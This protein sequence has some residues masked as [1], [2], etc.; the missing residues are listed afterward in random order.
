MTKLPSPRGPLSEQL[1]ERLAQ[2][3][4]DLGR[5]VAAALG[6]PLGDD[7]QLALF[8]LQEL[9]YRPIDGVD[10]AWE[11][12]P[13][14]V[15][16]RIRFEH[17]LE[18]L[19]RAAAG[20]PT[21]VD[22]GDVPDALRELV[23]A[24][25]GP[26]LSGWAQ[27]HAS[28]DHLR[29]FAVHRAAYQLKEADPHSTA[30]PRLP[31]GPAKTALLE[32]QLDEYGPQP[33]E[34]HAELFAET[35]RGLGLDPDD[36]PDLDRLPA[37]TLATNTSLGMLASSRRLVGALLGHLAVF[38]MTSVEPMSR[39]AAAV[40]RVLPGPDGTRAAR[41]YDVHVAA[42]GRHQ[43]VALDDMLRSFVAADPDHAADALLGA[44]TVLTVERTFA[45]H[46]L[47]RWMAGETSLRAPLPGSSLRPVGH[48]LALAG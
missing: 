38:E 2:P 8:V 34:A 26:S 45:E 27:A 5:G 18:E 16:L 36:A 14:A 7:A 25:G 22:P 44:A 3:P 24:A 19:L 43:H 42:D 33:G 39:Y 6:D 48:G 13:S 30:I 28:L 35:M 17:R 21:G 4:T 46:V 40:R 41:F 11:T 32:I 9:A 37:P 10:P 47:G 15:A 20:V 12:E 29:E 31:A 23:A 1:F